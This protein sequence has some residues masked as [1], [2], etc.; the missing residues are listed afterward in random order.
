M[1]L[2]CTYLM[3]LLFICIYSVFICIYLFINIWGG[4]YTEI[5]CGGLCAVKRVITVSLVGRIR[6]MPSHSEHYDTKMNFDTKN[7]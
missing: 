7:F 2:F 4:P 6:Y 1:Y 5:L 3:Y